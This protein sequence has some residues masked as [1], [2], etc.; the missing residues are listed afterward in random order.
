[1][2]LYYGALGYLALYGSQIL[3]TNLVRYSLMKYLPQT[4]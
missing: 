2:N 3:G 1:M 4:H